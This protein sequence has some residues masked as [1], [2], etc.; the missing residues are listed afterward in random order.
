MNAR[1][2][3]T[4]LSVALV[5][6]T[7]IAAASRTYAATNTIV[8]TVSV[9]RQ[10]AASANDPILPSALCVYAEHIKQEWLG[11]MDATDAWRDPILLVVRPRTP[12]QTNMP[13]IWMA[14]FQTDEHLKY[15]IHCLIPPRI[16]EAE[17]LTTI[18]DALC[19]EWANRKQIT[20]SGHPYTAPAMPTWLVQGLAA[21]IQ[22]RYEFLL[23]IAQRSVE[24]G[25]P[26]Q[27][28]DL[29]D[30]RVLPSD[31]MDRELFRADAWIFTESLL[32]LP[33]GPRKLQGFLSTLGEQKVASNAFWRIYQQDFPKSIA[34]EKWWSL[35]QARRTSVSL[36]QDLPVQETARRLDSILLTRLNSVRRRGEKAEELTVP[37]S[38]LWRYAD[39][40]WLN[41]VLKLKIDRLGTLRS[42]AH[43]LYQAV[44][45]KY[46]DAASWLYRGSV[47]RFRRG[48]DNAEAAQAVA[49][50][51]S[52]KIAAYMDQAERI[53]APQ[54]QSKVLAAYFQ[55]L[56]QFQKIEDERRNPISDYLDKF[57][58]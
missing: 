4:Q 29:L 54:E 43:P 38:N 44:V 17:L 18:V 34:L 15:Q 40:P 13:T 45:D 11:R 31:P 19:S 30:T 21:S 20:V 23:S 57:D 25:R 27:A 51:R 41:N 50:T 58:H 8:T 3:R 24:A 53:Y 22:G 2:S 35:E 1:R 42:Q 39:A 26:Q 6:L 55:T 36:A 52:G 28:A 37:I 49:E 47:I 56:A 12:A 9:S 48:I 14:V 46:I 5:A 16:D 7:Q 10:F 33:D 32:A